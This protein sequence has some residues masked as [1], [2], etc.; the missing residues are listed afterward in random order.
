MTFKEW[1]DTAEFLPGYAPINGVTTN[2]MEMAFNA[3]ARVE[4]TRLM[5]KLQEMRR[6]GMQKD[7]SRMANEAQSMLRWIESE[8]K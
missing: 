4:R 3:G 8:G 2:L 5:N 7:D 6:T 1:L